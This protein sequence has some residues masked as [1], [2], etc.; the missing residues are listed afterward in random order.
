MAAEGQGSWWEVGIDAVGLAS[1][2]YGRYLG[3]GIG[4]AAEVTKE[5]GAQATGQ[6][7][8]ERFIT[9]TREV[10]EAIRAN[11]NAGALDKKAATLAIRNLDRDAE[12]VAENAAQAAREAPEAEAG[13]LQ[14]LAAG[15]KENADA[16]KGANEILAEHPGDRAVQ[17]AAAEVRRLAGKGQ[18]NWFVAAGV[19]GTDKAL[20]QYWAGSYRGLK[21][22]STHGIGWLQ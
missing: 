4:R 22:Y 8:A 19:D 11:P 17:D 18:M 13:L 7:A 3:K 1:F 6:E 10:N 9:K 14:R 2:G 12:Q 20:N 21:D 15:S 5:A 16:F